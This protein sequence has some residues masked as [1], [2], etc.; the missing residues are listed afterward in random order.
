VALADV[1]RVLDVAGEAG[2]HEQSLRIQT[3]D[4][5]RLTE[6]QVADICED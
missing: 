1:T 4:L 3:A 5:M 6:A 2:S